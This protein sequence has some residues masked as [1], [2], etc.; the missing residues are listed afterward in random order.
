M[1]NEVM[2]RGL[3]DPAVHLADAQA[4][5]ERLEPL[6]PPA[7]PEPKAEPARNDLEPPEPEPEPKPEPQPV[8]SGHEHWDALAD[9]ESGRW[10][11]GGTSFVKGSAIWQW[12]KPGVELPPWGT[13]KHHGGLQFNPGTWNSFK[14]KAGVD[15]D[16][17]YNATREQQ[18]AVA[19]EV[20]EVQGWG[21]WPVCARKLNLR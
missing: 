5:E 20:Q 11:N 8:K 13:T 16:Y 12:A 7:P 1:P 21:A 6:P 17:A 3:E 19:I 18:I 10:L 15:I 4:Y 2:L 9:C 14:G